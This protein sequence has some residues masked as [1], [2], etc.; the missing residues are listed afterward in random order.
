[1][2][3]DQAL[4]GKSL[5]VFAQDL[6]STENREH[7][8][9]TFSNDGTELFF[10]RQYKEEEN[11]RHDILFMRYT[12]G[13]WSD[14]AKVPFTSNF[15]D[16]GTTFT[17]DGNRLFFG[18]RRSLEDLTVG[19][20]D[21]DIWY[22]DRAPEGFGEPV[23]IGSP[24]NTASNE[25]F[26]CLTRDNTLYF[27]S[28]KGDSPNMDLYYSQFE[29]G[30]YTEPVKLPDWINTEHGEGAVFVSPDESYMLFA[31]IK[32]RDSDF[33]V[34]LM[35]SFMKQDNTWSVPLSLKDRLG[36]IGDD[37]IIARVSPDNKYLF[38]LDHGDIKWIDADIIEELRMKE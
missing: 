4:P 33:G 29:N 34:D 17:S 15:L 21:T 25:G 26:P 13:R 6:V 7:S 35:L 24:V 16:D 32:F 22:I 31:R 18:S 3:P 9:V 1:E 14:P 8:S 37:L 23:N 28:D 20:E 5:S 10:T 36:L 11:S 2:Y 19:K 30:G 27:H 38:I 12:A